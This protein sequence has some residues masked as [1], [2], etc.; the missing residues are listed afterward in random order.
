MERDEVV[1]VVAANI[2]RLIQMRKTNPAEVARSANLNYT[3]IYDIIKGKSRSPRLD[4]ISKVAAAL[5][6]PIESLFKKIE[7]DD[8]V[9]TMVYLYSSLPDEEK[10]R[11][12]LTAKAWLEADQTQ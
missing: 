7:D 3:A 2:E 8:P 9:N 6:V 1:Q 10:K 11:L 5:N 12:L 4:T